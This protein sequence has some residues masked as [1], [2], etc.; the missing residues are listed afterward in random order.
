MSTTADRLRP[1]C[2]RPW[3][4]SFRLSWATVRCTW[5]RSWV[6]L[7]GRERSSSRRGLDGGSASV[8]SISARSSSR[9]TWRSN[10][11]SSWRG[12]VSGSRG[13]VPL[14]SAR[15][16]SVRRIRCTST[17]ITPEPSPWRPK[18]AI[19]SRARSRISPSEP[20]R[21]ASR[22]RSRSASRSRRSRGSP[23][24]PKRSSLRPLST[25]SRSTARKKKRSN[26][27]LNRWRSSCDLARVAASASRKSS[28]EVQLTASRAWVASSSSEVPTAMPSWR[29]SSANSSSLGA[30]PAGPERS[31]IP[32]Y[33]PPLAGLPGPEEAIGELHAH[34]L[35]HQVEVGS[36]L[37][38]DAHR[39]L[40]HALVDVLG[41]EQHEG[42][43]PV[44]RLRDRGRL[45]EVER[46][47]HVHDL[48]ELAGDLLVELGRVQAHDLELA[49]HVRVVEPE[50]ETAA[51]Q[52]LRELTRV[53]RG[54]EH[55]WM[56]P[57]L[58]HAQLG[59]RDLE[60]RQDLEQHRLELLVGLVDLV[61]QQHHRVIGG[62][63]GE[64]R[65]G[66]EELL[67]E[68]VLLDL[69]PTGVGRLGLDPQQ[70]LAVVPLVEGLGLVETLVAL[71]ADQAPLG[72]A[73]HG[74][75][76]LGLAHS[77]RALH[78]H[79]L[80]QLAGEEGDERGGL[81]GE[82]AD[83]PQSV[84][85]LFDRPELA[86]GR[87]RLK[88]TSVLVLAHLAL[89]ASFL[90]P[91]AGPDQSGGFRVSPTFFVLLFGIGFAVGIAGH[92]AKSRLLIA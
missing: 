89:L 47:H 80:A 38:D 28:R 49:L 35:C 36:V 55:E 63:G 79:G 33:S 42:P 73:R 10:C 67:A 61:D 25:A 58:H 2:S 69:L 8:R 6:G 44:D 23:S 17:P 51:L 83:F 22:I 92:L 53:V 52:R 45:L 43:G 13:S 48:H 19:A 74:L 71:E 39:A 34:A 62:Y 56:G 72:G 29:S 91:N 82:V 75:G 26:T 54:Q 18:A 11:W 7:D 60:V 14:R 20:A 87:H 66:E 88:D 15:R 81:V 1:R 5:L 57:R 16:P 85:G 90:D 86:A 30:I 76:E 32:P 50:I 70:L 41:A 27:R 84:A 9:R 59:Y 46:A 78:Q 40:E 12:T 21:M 64:E 3:V 37:D 68:D 77:G 24:P 31:G 4:A 65:A